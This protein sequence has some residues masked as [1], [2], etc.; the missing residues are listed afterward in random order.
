MLL[1]GTGMACLSAAVAVLSH[2]NKLAEQTLYRWT[3]CS[4][5]GL[6]VVS[7]EGFEVGVQQ[8]IQGLIQ[9]GWIS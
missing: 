4:W 6:A 7:E 3:L 9:R 2:A 8:G 5:D 1:P